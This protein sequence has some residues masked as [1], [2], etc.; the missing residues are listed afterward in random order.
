MAAVEEAVNKAIEKAKQKIKEEFFKAAKK[1]GWNFVASMV[2]VVG[3][4]WPAFTI[5]VWRE[6]KKNLMAPD[7]LLMFPVAATCDLLMM[8]LGLFD[9]ADLGI[10]GTAL[11]GLL[12]FPF[13]GWAW[14]RGGGLGGAQQE[15]PKDGETETDSE[16]PVKSADNKQENQKPA[17]QKNKPAPASKP[18]VKK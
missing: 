15:K 1:L 13:Y 10:L 14:V 7:A 18:S 3:D 5:F 9:W 16:A 17:G 6:T 8:I 11:R 12:W 2:P 4:F